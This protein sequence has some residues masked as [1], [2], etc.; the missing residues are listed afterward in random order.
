[1]QELL[2]HSDVGPTMIYTHVL[3]RCP[4]GV[5]L[6]VAAALV[7]GAYRGSM[8]HAAMKPMVRGDAVGRASMGWCAAG[9]SADRWGG[10]GSS[11]GLG[12]LC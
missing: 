7:R 6:P 5:R 1:M 3:K 9:C 2:G 10:V 4:A 11:A 8:Y 12:K